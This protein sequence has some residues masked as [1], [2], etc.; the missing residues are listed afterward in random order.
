[1]IIPLSQADTRNAGGKARGL[2]RLMKLGM[3]VPAGIVLIPDREDSWKQELERF[4]E[5]REDAVVA[6]RSSALAEDGDEASFAGQFESFLDCRGKKEIIHAVEKCMQ[7]G[8]RERVGSYREHFQIGGNG[9]I[10]VIIQEMVNAVRSG[11]IFTA[12]PVSG[13]VDQWLVSVT[14]GPADDLLAGKSAGEQILLTRNGRILKPGTLLDERQTGMLYRQARKIHEHFRRPVDLEWAMDD[15]GTI[16]WLQARPVTTIKKVH[17]NELDGGLFAEDEIFTR[18]NIGEMM[19]GPVTPLTYSVFGRA[20]EVGLQDFYIAS[21]ALKKF[22]DDWL[23]FRMF[24]NHLFFSMTR[25]YDI[26]GSVLLNKKENLD[27]A[28]MGTTLDGE[29]PVRTKP[30]PIRFWNLIRQVRYMFSGVRRMKELQKMAAEFTVRE[31]PDPGELYGELDRGL[32]ILNRAYAHHYCTSSQSGTYQSIVM[33]ILSRGKDRPD[34]GDYRDAASLMA[35]L[36]NVESADVVRSIDALYADFG[37]SPVIMKWIENLDDKEAGRL[38]HPDHRAGDDSESSPEQIR[39]LISRIAELMERHGHRSVREAELREKSWSENP[40]Q[41]IGLIRKRFLAGAIE[42]KSPHDFNQNRQ[43]I[44]SGLGRMHRL[45]LKRVLPAA[46]AAVARRELTKSLSIGI[47]QIIKKA[48]LKL[49]EQLVEKGLLDDVDQVFFLTHRELGECIASGDTEWKKT[50]SERRAV[51]PEFF[52]LR[53]PDVSYGY[54]EPIPENQASP[55]INGNAVQGLPVSAGTIEATVRVIEKL[56]DADTLE[57][58]EIMVCQYTD[59]GWT[60][61]FSLAGGLITEIG[62]PLSHGAVVAREYGIPAVVNAKGALG[63][64]RTGETVRLDGS[65]G[66]VSKLTADGKL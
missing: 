8:G 26:T 1:M 46:R 34:N 37:K 17:L 52:K 66:V 9:R 16:H 55:R 7:S 47:Q 58:G 60:P 41:L 19:P 42:G 2:A 25:M 11:V 51:S 62:S 49:A 43:R 30:F 21:G 20:I 4:P 15:S 63:F 28:I 32:D 6:V 18:A 50:A 39:E 48:Y 38:L 12:N 14:G 5:G 44:L 10:P 53:F 64:F 3:N 22:T 40:G 35:D 56:E 23:Y 24:Y 45:V 57:P 65:S 27:F 54:P 61:Y 59:I 31:N 13:R 33:G 36:R 29:N